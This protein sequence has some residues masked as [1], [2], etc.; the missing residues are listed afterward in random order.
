MADTGFY[1]CERCGK[2]KPVDSACGCGGHGQGH[3]QGSGPMMPLPEGWDPSL[4]RTSRPRLR[5]VPGPEH[6]KNPE[7]REPAAGEER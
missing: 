7:T 3:G 5:L 1:T 4:T 2:V 6:P